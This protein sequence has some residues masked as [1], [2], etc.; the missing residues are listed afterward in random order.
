MNKDLLELLACPEC[1]SGNLTLLSDPD[2]IGVACSSCAARYPIRNG[3]PQMLPAPLGATLREK[4]T[5]LGRLRASRVEGKETETENIE[6]DRFMWEHQ[7]YNW[8]KE[9]IYRDSKAADIFFSYTEK[10][11]RALCQFLKQR[12]GG[13]DGKRLLY[14]GCG[15]DRLVSLPLE[16]EGAFIV[17]LDIVSEP[18]EDLRQAGVQNCVCG[19]ARRLPFQAEAFDVVF[20]KGSVHH[21]HPIAEP[22]GAMARVVKRRGHIIIAEPSK[23]MLS[24]L[25]RLLLPAGLGYPTPY[26]DAISAQEVIGILGKE[27]ISRFQIATLTH[28]PPGTPAPI[29]RLW[30]RLGKAMPW[31]FNRFAF[32]FMVYG[33]K[34]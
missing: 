33:Q 25:H 24:H 11:A 3:I 22:L 12:V 15:N 21:S 2:F 32:E 31:L 4:N 23:Y 30:E 19:D 5:Y 7:L 10:G 16:Q 14:V 1:G 34:T 17:S 20:S 27:G 9:V 8:G 26:E 18:L 13:V 28:A 6:I 29:A